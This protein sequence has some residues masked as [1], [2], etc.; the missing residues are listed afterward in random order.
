MK[1]FFLIAAA[2][3]AL[4][5]C[6]SGKSSIPNAALEMPMTADGKIDME[7]VPVMEFPQ[8]VY[9]FGKIKEGEKVSFA[10]TFKNIGKTPLIISDASAS[11]GCTVPQ[12]PEDPIEPGGEGMIKVVFN[13]EGKMG[14]QNKSITLMANTVPN[15]KVL[16]LR[17]EVIPNE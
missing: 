4:A 13:S 17:G 14:I 11:C 15:T 7:K 6:D 2:I 9:D 3:T 10:F 5:A 12:K 8:E 1:K 16:Y